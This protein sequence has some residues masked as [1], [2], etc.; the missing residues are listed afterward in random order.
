MAKPAAPEIDKNELKKLLIRSKK[1]PVNCAVGV[2]ADGSAVIMLDKIKQ[3]RA[4]FKKMEEEYGDIKNGRWGTAEVD[5]DADPKL[6]ILTI[7]KAASGL[8]RKMKKTLKGTTFTKVRVMLEGGGVDEEEMEDDEEEVTATPGQV[9]GPEVLSDDEPA[10]ATGA[11]PAPATPAPEPA[12]ATGAAPASAPATE[13]QGIDFKQLAADLTVAVRK[14]IAFVDDKEKFKKLRAMADKVQASIKANN[15]NAV[16]QMYLL[17]VELE[18]GS[19]EATTADARGGSTDQA[20]TPQQTDPGTQAPQPTGATPPQP[21]AATPPQ[22]APSTTEG[23]SAGTDFKA[24]TT[25]LTGLVKKMIPIKATDANRFAELKT[26]ADGASAAIKASRDEA[27]AL[28]HA[29]EAAIDGAGA[30]APS[31]D[32]SG[33]TTSPQRG[34]AS[35]QDNSHSQGAP[36][37][38]PE[39]LAAL[40]ASPK[41]WSDTVTSVGGAIDKLK[42]AIRKDFA[43]EG[44]DV[45]ADIEK[46]LDRISKITERFDHSLADLLKAAHEATD[47]AARRANITKAKSVLAEHIKYAASE[48]LIAMLDDNPFGVSTDIK[49]TLV[50][51]LQQ[52]VDAV[53]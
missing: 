52:L 6:V 37:M 17:N 48:P 30:A 7:N 41:L 34:E 3:P 19:A 20:A 39:K 51:N 53:R 31:T 45:V 44:P 36:V 47:E 15:D 22:P 35:I 33:A 25:E 2:A 18:G 1:E 8:A 4:V 24:L 26:M 43:S 9:R 5:V 27:T 32:Q 14:M 11:A 49:K 40:G 12:P 29:L 42:D 38:S 50:A 16:E 28:V 21:T 23:A 46:N 13:E 10:P